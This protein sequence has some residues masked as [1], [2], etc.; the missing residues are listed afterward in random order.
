MADFQKEDKAHSGELRYDLGQ[1]SK[2]GNCNQIGN[3]GHYN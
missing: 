3:I 1:N 2:K